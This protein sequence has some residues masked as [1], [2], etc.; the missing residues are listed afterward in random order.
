MLGW[1][2]RASSTSVGEIFCP[3]RFMS[4]LNFTGYEQVSIT[5]QVAKITGSK[6]TIEESLSVCCVI[7]FVSVEDGGSP[8]RDLADSPDRYPSTLVVEKG[9]IIM[10]WL[11][12][13]VAVR[14]YLNHK[15]A[16]HVTGFRGAV[17]DDDWDAESF[18]TASAA[19]GLRGPVP[20]RIKRKVGATRSI[21]AR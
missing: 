14:A 10:Y 1:S 4:S 2:S 19:S 20:E 21:V 16:G 12:D 18:S 11:A 7:I 15:V 5:V 8:G 6:P 3:P 13:A 9:D 17:G